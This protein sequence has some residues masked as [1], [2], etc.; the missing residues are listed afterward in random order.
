MRIKLFC[1]ETIVY[2]LSQLICWVKVQHINDHL[3][4]SIDKIME[5]QEKIELLVP[6]IKPFCP[7]GSLALESSIANIAILDRSELTRRSLK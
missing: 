7:S 1:E 6:G 4:E 2:H 3:M 5:R